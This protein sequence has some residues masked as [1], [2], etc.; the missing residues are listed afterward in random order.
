[1]ITA[2]FS[3]ELGSWVRLEPCVDGEFS[4]VSGFS[5]KYASIEG[6]HNIKL[7]SEPPLPSFLVEKKEVEKGL[8]DRNGMPSFLSETNGN[9]K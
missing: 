9:S 7:Y 8:W 1:M 2:Y 3:R 6:N 5:N 4:H